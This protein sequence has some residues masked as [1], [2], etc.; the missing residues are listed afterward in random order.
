MTAR[1]LHL[2]SKNEDRSPTSLKG[3]SPGDSITVELSDPNLEA[4]QRLRI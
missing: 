3:F 4:E 2:Q 1:R